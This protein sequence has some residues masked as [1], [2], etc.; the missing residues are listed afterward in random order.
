MKLLVNNLPLLE[1]QEKTHLTAAANTSD[2]T[3]TVQSGLG[4]GLSKYVLIGNFGDEDAEIH[5]THSSTASTY[6]TITLNS[7][8]IKN[9]NI[10][11]PVTLID[12]NQVEFSRASTSGG[13]K[14]VLTTISIESDQT[15]TW[16]DDTTNSTGY[17][18]VRFKNSTTN[19]YSDYSGEVPYTGYT[20]DAVFMVKKSALRLN[21]YILGQGDD[22]ELDQDDL[23][24]FINECRQEVYNKYPRLSFFE[25]HDS[26]TTTANGTASYSMPTGFSPQSGTIT[27]NTGNEPLLRLSRQKYLSLVT[28]P[29]TTGAPVYYH[30]WDG[31][32]YLWPV[33]NEAK[34]LYVDYYKQPTKLTSDVDVVGIWPSVVKWYVAARIAN[35]RKDKDSASEYQKYYE[36]QL[37]EMIASNES[38]MPEEPGQVEITNLHDIYDSDDIFII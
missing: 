14:T 22:A 3:L 18:Y 15:R 12:Y 16:Y 2:T 37:T 32:I 27:Y 9:H 5:L 17:G 21:N 38:Y 19:V 31:L 29:N 13:T 1:G 11:D 8:L 25:E 36:K 7:A 35:I 10:D 24:E 23:L 33:P 28:S 30:L 6:T 34:T 26:S 20:M 4:F